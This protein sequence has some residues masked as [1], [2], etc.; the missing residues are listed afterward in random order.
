MAS[1]HPLPGC[2]RRQRQTAVSSCLLFSSCCAR[3]ACISPARAGRGAATTADVDQ[4][5]GVRGTTE[6]S[7]EQ[8]LSVSVRNFSFQITI[9]KPFF[10]KIL[11]YF[12]AASLYYFHII[13]LFFRSVRRNIKIPIIVLIWACLLFHAFLQLHCS[14]PYCVRCRCCA[15]TTEAWQER[16]Q[17]VTAGLAGG[18]AGGGGGPLALFRCLKC[19]P[20]CETCKGSEPCLAH[21]NWPFRLVNFSRARIQ[22]RN[23][24]HRLRFDRWNPRRNDARSGTHISISRRFRPRID[25]KSKYFWSQ[26]CRYDVNFDSGFDSDGKISD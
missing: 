10:R 5:T 8:W 19:A 1:D 21:Y 23:F 26:R 3:S 18:A 2:D 11:I 6:C 16:Q 13:F 20:G 22:G 24:P 9:R 12:N 17:N 7:T 25:V 4:A 14:D 15:A